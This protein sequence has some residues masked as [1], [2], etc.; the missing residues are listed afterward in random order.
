M[1]RTAQATTFSS[2]PF[3]DDRGSHG[4]A[5]PITEFVNPHSRPIVSYYFPKGVGEHH[6]GERHPMKP[7]RLTLTN[8]LVM[9]YGLDK[10][11]HHIYNPR[12]ATQAELEA[13]H[14]HDYID[15]L[16]R[17]TPRNQSEMR[18]L[19]DT[20]NCVEDCPIFAEMYDFC[21]M[22]A[23]GSLAGARKLCAGTCDIAI[24]WSGGLH[25]AKR[26]EASGFCYVNDVVLAILEL[27]RYHPRVL[28]I[29][30]DIHHGDGVELAF[31]HSNRVMTVSFHKYTGEFFPGTGKLDD[32][33]AGIGKHF[34]L[35]VPLQDGIDD[36][37]YLTIFKTVIEDTVT[38]FRPTSI[39]LQCGADSLG[40]DRLGAFNLS[41]AAHGE[42]V[43]FVRKFNV[44][45]L[46]LGGGGYTI[47]NVSR[48]WAYET[49]VLVG[50]SIP[51]ELPATVYDPFFRDSQ[52]KL[53]PPLTGRVE[54]QNSPASLQ[55]ITISTRNKLR[56]LQGAPSVAMQEIP[57]DL[58]GLL[59][60]EDRT[61]DERDEEQGTALAGEGRNDRSIARNEFYD[62][63]K[64][65]DNDESSALSATKTRASATTRRARGTRRTRGRG[66]S[67]TA[68]A[69]PR[70]EGE[71]DPEEAP[72]TASSR[73]AKGKSRGKGRAR[74]RVKSTDKDKDKGTTLTEPDLDPDPGATTPMDLEIDI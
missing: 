26:G 16:S 58:E 52:W 55:R 24:N 46:I 7:H 22:Y 69:T 56:Y 66:R 1:V 8:A 45:L 37:M 57:P 36:D 42:C 67:K 21:R 32:N 34:C 54:N 61:L 17:V 62:G 19:I 47:K 60:D 20:F 44:P 31:Y 9:G 13:Y 12:P 25:H 11:I 73:G 28:Y 51:D 43:N 30:I 18:H 48:C 5:Q 27:L 40:C 49:A 68:P 23:G 59:A 38:A 65:V 63:E 74:P 10:Q 72:A 4:I 70:E 53:H 35:N 64:D 3:F 2:S 50:A 33:G 39:V 41:I 29:D 15:F 14:D 71:D 6:Y